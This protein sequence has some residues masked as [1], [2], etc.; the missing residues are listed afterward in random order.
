LWY[1]GR[2]DYA[3]DST[4]AIQWKG[5]LIPNESGLH[6]FH[7]LCYD[8]KEYSNGDTLK[9]V[10]TSVEQY[11]EKINLETGKEYD[12]ILETENRS[13]G[14]ARMILRWKTLQCLLKNNPK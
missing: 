5:K 10:Y 2:P 7:L 11:T 4:Y 6:Q 14:A 8:A 3:T 12:F 1:T 13:T 9:M